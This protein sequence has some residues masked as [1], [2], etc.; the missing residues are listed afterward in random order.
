M[1]FDLDGARKE[2]SDSEIIEYLK[3][4]TPGFDFDMA[5]S[6]GHSL[7]DIVG[8]INETGYGAE[9]KPVPTNTIGGVLSEAITQAETGPFENKWIRNKVDE[10]SSAYGPAQLTYSLAEGYLNNNPDMFDDTEKEYLGRFIE[11]G[12][13]I[14][15]TK[16]KADAVYGLGGTGTLTSDDDKGTYQVVVAK[17][18]EEIYERNGGDLDKTW[19]EWR[20]GPSGGEDERYK[21]EFFNALEAAGAFDEE[22]VEE[23][24]VQEPV[25]NEQTAVD[26]L[27]RLYT[28]GFISTD[29]RPK[30]NPEHEQIIGQMAGKPFDELSNQDLSEIAKVT[31]PEYE[32]G[33]PIAQAVKSGLRRI[34]RAPLQAVKAQLAAELQLK[35]EKREKAEESIKFEEQ[36]D[37]YLEKKYKEEG[38][39]ER[40]VTKEEAQYKKDLLKKKEKISTTEKVLGDIKESID[41]VIKSDLVRG[42]IVDRPDTDVLANEKFVQ[43]V[44]ESGIPSGFGILLS[45]ATKNPT[46]GSIYMGSIIAGSTAENLEQEGKDPV[47]IAEASLANALL[48][49]PLERIGLGSLT[50]GLGSIAKGALG[51]GTEVLTEYLQEYVDLGVEIY[52]DNPEISERDFLREFSKRIATAEFQKRA[53]YAGA[54]A[55]PMAGGISLTTTAM[56]SLMEHDINKEHKPVKEGE[57]DQ[58]EIDSREAQKRDLEKQTREI[59][60]HRQHMQNLYGREFT[61]DEA[62]T[63]WLTNKTGDG[64]TLAELYRDKN[65]FDKEIENIRN[66]RLSDKEKGIVTGDAET[67]QEGVDTEATG[68]MTGD[69]ITE[70]INTSALSSFSFY[71]FD[72]ND[73]TLDDF[74]NEVEQYRNAGA[75]VIVVKSYNEDVGDIYNAFVISDRNRL[76]EL[77]TAYKVKGSVDDFIQRAGTETFAERSKEWET[78]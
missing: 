37:K 66:E 45:I 71:D 44:L 23:E 15:N 5:V 13:K 69:S 35:K 70:R 49:M 25:Y 1:P 62:A 43:D 56:Q 50:K 55:L 40:K 64:E 51:T 36:I 27:A 26:E 20:F 32:S 28:H 9:K 59:E 10:A 39:G 16:D 7:D 41:E 61:I 11:Q 31:V 18:L 12:K 75:E 67:A 4:T 65:P 6:D 21:T 63:D 3:Q 78:I 72:G 60:L 2:F 74:N 8:Y 53:G 57:V 33:N 48:Q 76:Q 29:G 42:K 54:V 24:P 46:L 19:S 14:I 30:L 52:A 47:T 73:I 58:N 34:P 17:M 22:P 38:L 68:V 77:L